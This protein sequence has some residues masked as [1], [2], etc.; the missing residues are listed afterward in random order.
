MQDLRVNTNQIE[1]QVRDYQGKGDAI[2]FLHFS[3]ANL[4]MWQRVT[5]LFQNGYRVI[6]VDLRG[7]GRSD[8]PD[9]SYHIDEMARDI[10]GVM[11]RMKLGTA[12]II[13]SS[14][15][16]EVGLSL[17]AN[18][19]EKVISLVCD[20]A[21][22]S[23]FGPYGTWEGSEQEFENDVA[24][25]LKQMRDKPVNLYSSVEELVE[26]RRGILTK[27]GLWNEYVEA[28]EIYG[29]YDTG[30][31]KFTCGMGKLANQ[32]Y[33]QGY[34]HCRL[35]D[36]YS[37]VFCPLLMIA[38]KENEN[39]VEKAAMRGLRDLAK[40]ARIAEISGWMHPYGW[41]LDPDEVCRVILDFLG[42][43]SDKNSGVDL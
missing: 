3:S 27:Y 19:P 16:A 36:Y 31:G 8:R 39:E 42:N 10:A 38:E 7:H 2:I 28:M 5:P 25:T 34:F 12:H 22:S 11:E 37:K 15:G 17:A 23:E 29:A 13:G 20:G 6:L 21:L 9:A 26:A 30:D 35:E 1:L 14:L 18:Y 43:I 24:D 41:L 4:M 33:M 40:Q 32:S